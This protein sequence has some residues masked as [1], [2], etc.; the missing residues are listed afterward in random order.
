MQ[1]E[2]TA[3][4]EEFPAAITVTDALGTILAM[5]GRARETFAKEGGGA[6]IG[7]SVFDCHPEPALSRTRELYERQRAN[8]YT[9][10]KQ[11]VRKMIHQ[12]PWY[13]E[14]I[15]AGFIEIALPVPDSMPHFHRE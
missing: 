12:I 13:R 4:I 5:N 7:H 15:F 10:D 8:H 3:W 1:T 11:G 9:I 14:G 6:L 2:C